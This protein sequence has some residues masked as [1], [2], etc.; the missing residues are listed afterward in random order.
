VVTGNAQESPSLHNFAPRLGAAWRPFGDRTVIRG[1]YGIFTE[2][3]GRFARVLNNGPFQISETF[4]NAL[5]NG[6][7]LFAFPNPFPPGAGQVASQSITSYPINTSNGKIHQFNVSVERQIKDVGIRLSYVGARDRGMNYSVNINKPAA[8]LIPFTQSRRPFPQ[9]MSGSIG[10]ND[11]ALNYNAFTVEGLRKM[12]SLT[13]DAHW[14]WTSNYL[15]Y[16]NIEDPLRAIAVEPRSVQLEVPRRDHVRVGAADRAWEEVPDE[17]G[18]ARG[19]RVRRVAGELGKRHGDGSVLYSQLLGF[20]SLEYEHVGRAARSDC[21][22]QFA[23][24]PADAGALVRCR[25]VRGA[26]ARQL[27]Q[28]VTVLAA[29]AGAECA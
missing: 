14:T 1:S 25:S 6:Q 22:W 19:L 10:R 12:G 9:F 16:Q 3:L 27:R 18:S 8:S 13:F 15:N 29:W 24:R 5:T 11:G 20:G 2:T 28:C 7:F 21:Q 4:N 17:C 26:E 23:S